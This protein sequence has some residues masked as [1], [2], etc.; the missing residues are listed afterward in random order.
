[1]EG[2]IEEVW[3]VKFFKEEGVWDGLYIGRVWYTG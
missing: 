3:M 1:M 2:M